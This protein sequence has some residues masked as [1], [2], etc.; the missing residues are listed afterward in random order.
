MQRFLVL[1]C[2]LAGAGLGGRV[3]WITK[4]GQPPPLRP[5]PGASANT[6]PGLLSS[7]PLLPAPPSSSLSSSGSLHQLEGQHNR[8]DCNSRKDGKGGWMW[9]GEGGRLHSDRGNKPLPDLPSLT[10]FS[11]SAWESG[12]DHLDIGGLKD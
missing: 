4:D 1:A 10:P 7:P 6:R 9:G 5:A 2:D 11:L 12:R 8:H 3:T